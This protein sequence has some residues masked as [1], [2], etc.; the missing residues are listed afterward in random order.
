MLR[1]TCRLLAGTALLACLA[2]AAH[3]ADSAATAGESAADAAAATTAEESVADAGTTADEDSEIVVLG[4]GQARQVQT[5]SA[6]DINRL[7]PGTTPIK[8]IS[9]LPGVNYQ[10]ADAF[11]AYEWSSRITLRGFNQN[12][13]GFTLDGVPLGDMS[14]GNSN[15][16]HISRAIISEN[17]GS[18]AVAQGSGALGTASTSNLGGT[19]EFSS[20]APSDRFDIVGSATYG[21]NDTYRGFIR[22]ESGDITGNGLK[23]YLS[24][25]YLKTDK[26]KGYG[27]QKQHQVNAK[28]VQDFG[29]RGSIT[30]FFNFSDRREQD[31][32]DLSLDLI[33]RLGYNVDNISNN[34]PLALQLAKIYA[35]QNAGAGRQPY[36]GLGTVFPAPY[37]TVDDVYF[38]AG[39]LR[40]DYLAGATFAANLTDRLSVKLTGYYHDNHGQGVWYLPYVPTPGGAAISVRTTEYDIHRGGA[41]GHVAYEAG[42][43]R[44]EIGGWYESN[45]FQ[46]ARRFYG[47]ADQQTPS[48]PTLEFKKN[49]FFTQFDVKFDT[50]TMLY[51]V[52]DRLELGNLT[53]S[54]GWKGYKVRNDARRIVGTLAAGRIEA[55]DWFLP[56]AGALY[57]IGD[58]TEVF[59][60]FTQNMRAFTS[61]AVGGSPFATTQAGLNLIRGTL[62]PERSDTYEAGA[63]FRMDG[64]QASIAGYYVDFSNR[65]LSLPNGTGGAGNPTTLQN[66]GS[67]RNYGVE[68]TALYRPFAPLSLLGSYSYNRSEYR[69]DVISTAFGSVGQ[70]A[71][72][73]KGKTVPD[74]PKHLLKGEI[75]YDDGMFLGRVG[76]DY[77]SKRFFNYLNDRSVKGRVI[78]DASIGFRFPGEGALKGFSIEGSVTNL[79]DKKYV[80]TIGSNG[81]TA[82]GDNQTLLAGAPRQFFVTVKRGL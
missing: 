57:K 81:F 13:L 40:R 45:D 54:G 55:R 31:Y 78:M 35:N 14:Y 60:S 73:T 43:N 53:L 82:T 72:A 42:P 59:A 39:G 24:Y 80:S 49:P 38:D 11:G 3:A 65:L 26:W 27:E 69:D 33:N 22:V 64:F 36:P 17:L 2:S 1:R 5:I 44:I 8:A 68:L 30:G 50:Q 41:L 7:T 61:A 76:A 29:D 34:F 10:A 63:R 4:F 23:G 15:G 66:V 37:Q 12:Q 77:M 46:N 74:A 16:L 58:S 20:L 71:I 56:Q 19:I 47:L 75:A 67:V 21:S 9:K 48:L 52:A 6:A 79:T 62:K 25:G 51:Y 32:Q 18:A 28:I 70:V